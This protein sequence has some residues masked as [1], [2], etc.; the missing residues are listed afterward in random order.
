MR[1]LRAGVEV[2]DREYNMILIQ[3]DL[4]DSWVIQYWLGLFLGIICFLISLAWMIHM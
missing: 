1:K 3:E 4:N 2:L